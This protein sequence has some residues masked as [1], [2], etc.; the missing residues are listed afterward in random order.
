[1]KRSSGIVVTG[2]FVEQHG[3]ES[4]SPQAAPGGGPGSADSASSTLRSIRETWVA[5]RDFA[6]RCECEGLA[7]KAFRK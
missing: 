2:H 3:P 4:I 7:D 1:M 5:G 6:R